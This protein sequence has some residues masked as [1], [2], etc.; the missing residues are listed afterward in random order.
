MAHTQEMVA[1][2]QCTHHKKVNKQLPLA[3]HWFNNHYWQYIN[4]FNHCHS[5]MFISE[6]IT[7]N[8]ISV[9]MTLKILI[10]MW[11]TSMASIDKSTLRRVIP[12]G[13]PKSVCKSNVEMPFLGFEMAVWLW[14]S[15]LMTPVCFTTQANLKMHIWCKFDDSSSNLFPVIVQTSQIFHN[16]ESK[17]PKWPRSSRS[18]IPIFDTRQED[19]MIHIWCNLVI[20]V[21][22]YFHGQ[23]EFP[24]IL[25]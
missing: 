16:Y 9:N 8:L 15:M 21:K 17:W 7:I 25:S 23:A 22:S 13:R 14:R 19:P 4:S 2:Q 3:H 24:R 1:D 20:P 18:M 10:M 11:D 6:M 12:L 5:Q